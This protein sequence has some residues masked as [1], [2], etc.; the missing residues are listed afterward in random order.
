M[1]RAD[2]RAAT[3]SS[4]APLF[5]PP[6]AVPTQDAVS[7]RQPSAPGQPSITDRW[8]RVRGWGGTAGVSVRL[9]AP[10]RVDALAE[11]VHQAQGEGLGVIGRGMGRSYGD[12]AQLDGGLVVQMTRLKEFELDAQR[13]ILT[14]QAGITLGELLDTLVPAGWMIPVLPGT[15]HVSVGGAIASDIHGK[16]H[17]VAG[18]FGAHVERLGLL[19]SRGEVLELDP[20]RPDRLFEA[21]VGGMGLTGLILWAQVRLSRV[22]SSVMSVDTD[23][24]ADLDQAFAALRAPGGPYRVAWIDVLA[25][26]SGRGVVT[27]AEHLPGSAAGASS[28]D[29]ASRAQRMFSPPTTKTSGTSPT[30][31]ARA[32][33]PTGWPGWPLRPATVRV[34]NELRF[35]MTPRAERGRPEG[36]GTHLFPLD[37]LDAWPRLYGRGGFL[38]YQ[39]VVPF[40]SEDVLWKVIDQLHRAHLPC[41]LAVLKDFGDST[42]APLSFPMPGWTLTLD[43]PRQAAG[44]DAVLDRFDELV[45]ASGGRVYLSKDVRMRAGALEAMYPRLSEWRE[46][47][48]AAD[49]DQLWRSDLGLRTGLVGREPA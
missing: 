32:T 9:A 7:T 44:L 26:R 29:S 47:R 28:S 22:S 3:G 45:A 42:D 8:A 16:N 43:I 25:S 34:F 5:P 33:V 18:T 24:V 37:V 17:G 19:S 14:A 35:R 15:Q 49:P 23:R 13:G 27:R 20:G 6:L 30:V 31:R 4:A 10:D 12:A 21:T 1:P 2:L 36:I 39:L 46:L 40:G 11:A 48:Q 38:Q 41:Y